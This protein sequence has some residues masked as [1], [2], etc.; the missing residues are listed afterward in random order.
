MTSN[1]NLN[2]MQL[3]D[4]QK[5]VSIPKTVEDQVEET[6]FVKSGDD[7]IGV[8]LFLP[9]SDNC[10][11][12]IIGES[13]EAKIVLGTYSTSDQQYESVYQGLDIA[14]Q[15]YLRSIKGDTVI[16]GPEGPDENPY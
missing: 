13:Y 7:I 2:N 5:E 10:V 8:G 3:E 14:F 1:I 9:E 4:L 12:A 11:L 6:W 16:E 15:G